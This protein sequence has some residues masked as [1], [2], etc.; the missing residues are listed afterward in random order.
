MA[1]L[2]WI[3]AS[4]NGT[5]NDTANWS[6]G[7]TPGNN[8]TL[9]FSH[10]GAGNVTTMTGASAL[11]GITCIIEMGYTGS[12]GSISAAAVPTYLTF[13]GGTFH[14][15]RRT[16]Q[17]SGTGSPLILVGSTLNTAAT[18]NVY[19]SSSTSTST[20]FPPILLDSGTSNTLNLFGGNVGICLFA[21][22]NVAEAATFGVINVAASDDAGVPAQLTIGSGV[23]VT[24]LTARGGTIID[25]ADQTN[26]STK[27]NDNC[28][29]LVEGTG[30]HTAIEVADAA[31]L[32]YWGT[33]TI[34]AGHVRGGTLDFSGDTRAKTVTDLSVYRGATLNVDNGEAGSVTFT[35]AIQYPDGMGEVAIITPPGVK[36]TLLSI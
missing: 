21:P 24:A 22:S 12:I 25:R 23:T 5:F 9:I 26:A 2:H 30:A 3:K 36:G 13:D 34:T 6:N 35:N 4:G 27:I 29:M 8:D 11:T 10:L 33:G 31:T 28:E 18:F 32:K 16:S 1:V 7:A 14:I 17:G 15:G 19:D 20:N